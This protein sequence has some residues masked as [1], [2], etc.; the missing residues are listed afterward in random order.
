MAEIQSGFISSYIG[1]FYELHSQSGG[2][3]NFAPEI[4]AI[5]KISLTC[6]QN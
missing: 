4:N 1:K 5:K 6:N 2:Q 3:I